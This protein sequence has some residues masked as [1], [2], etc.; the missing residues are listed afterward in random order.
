MTQLYLSQFLT[1][2]L[3]HL[4]AVASPG[5]DFAI[6]VRQSFRYGKTTSLWTSLGVGCGILVHV[7]YSILGVGLII[8]RSIM[9]FSFIKVICALYLLYVGIQS[10]QATPHN[11]AFA[12]RQQGALPTR[13]QAIMSGFLTNG[14]N[15]KAT[16]FFLSLFTVVIDHTTPVAVQVM[17]GLY[18]AVATG[19]WFALLSLFLGQNVVRAVLFKAGHWLERFTGVILILLGAELVITS[20]T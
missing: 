20:H 7:S 1:I 9:L 10:I 8:S 19:A 13:R 2:A 18:M 16:L 17:Y 6:I 11:G 4:L 14:L 12:C 5:P 3:V 15:P